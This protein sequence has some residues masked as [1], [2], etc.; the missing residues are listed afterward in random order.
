M[1]YFRKF[2]KNVMTSGLNRLTAIA[3]TIGNTNIATSAGP[4]SSIIASILAMAFGV[5]PRPTP[6]WP[7][8][9]TALS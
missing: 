9:I 5:W 7:A 2:I 8:T 4:L 6:Q 3:K 1:F